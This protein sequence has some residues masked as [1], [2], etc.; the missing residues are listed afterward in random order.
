[1]FQQNGIPC[2]HAIVFIHSIKK[3]PFEYVSSFYLTENNIKAY[4][5]IIKPAGIPNVQNPIPLKAP[6][7]TKK[8]WQTKEKP[9]KK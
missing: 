7:F 6:N 9:H 2:R 4:S 5:L 1:M 3:S 8:N